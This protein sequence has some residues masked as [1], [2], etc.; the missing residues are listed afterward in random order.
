MPTL[1]IAP[2]SL[3]DSISR[4]SEEAIRNAKRLYLQTSAHPSAAWIANSQLS[5]ESMDDLFASCEDFDALN[6]AIASRLFSKDGDAVYAVPG[7]GIGTSQL[8]A[9]KEAAHMAKAEIRILPGI[10]YAQSILSAMGYSSQGAVTV[11]AAELESVDIHTDRMF[12]I[13]ELDTVIRAGEVK[14]ALGEFYPDDYPLTLGVLDEYG[15]Y[16]LR[17]IR[18]FELDRQK[19]QSYFAAT[20]AVLR[21]AEMLDL[22]RFGFEELLNVMKRL[23]APGGCP[24]DAKQTHESLRASLLEESYEVLQTIDD[25]DMSGMCE[26]LGDLLLQIVFHAQLEEEK[27][28][29]TM[30]DVT[31]GIVSKLIYRHPHVFGDVKADTADEVLV[32]WDKLKMK[33]KHFE[34]QSDAIDVI[35][36]ALPALIRSSKV[37]KKAA[38]VGFDWDSPLEALKKV[39]EEADELQ[40]AMDEK[41]A[42]HIREELGDLLFACV[43]VVRLSHENGELLLQAA[44]DKFSSRFRLVEEA[45]LQDGKKLEEMDLEEMDS[46]WDKA[47]ALQK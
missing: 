2:L 4:A 28:V 33:E 27:R 38:S 39:Y 19:P 9:I 26:E 16:S 25:G 6:A 30:R 23:R 45:V 15:Q 13:E 11:S 5:Y 47:K 24:W 17:E 37:Q 44:T 10:G 42:E 20:T 18:L 3:P 34:L 35:P 21:P 41:D 29:F 1:T 46:Y 7:A 14:L 32:N 31:S 43:N 40:A 8:D 12:C 22:S 36:R